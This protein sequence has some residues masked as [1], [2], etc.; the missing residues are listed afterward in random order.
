MPKQ[1]SAILLNRYIW[2]IDTIYSAGS[3]SREEIDRRW[4]RSLLSEGEMSIPPRT[5]HR[6]RIAIEE[7]FQI[8]IGF[9]KTRGYFIENTTDYQRQEMRKWLVN[10]FSV[11]N[12]INEGPHLRQHISF[13]D[14]PSS[15]RFLTTILEAIRDR[16]VLQVTHRGFTKPEPSTFR[17]KPYGL[18]VFKQRW[19]VL[20]ESEYADHQLRTYG[21]D[22]FESV[23]RLEEH[24]D[25]PEDFDIQEYFSGSYGITGLGQK[26]ELIKLEVNA[27]QR[28]YLRTLPLHASQKEI[29]TADDYSVFQFHLVPTF[30]LR[31]EILSFGPSAEVLSPQHFRDE[32]R[33]EVE[34]M[35]KLYNL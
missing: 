8:N 7:L 13:E 21:L 26:P 29:E 34:K 22:R 10:T 6:W 18:K 2:L 23:E 30:E 20:A 15:Q 32:L 24:Y 16:V 31:Q 27:Q 9:N 17:L 1:N 11:N 14:I 4:C 5:F 25:I 33:E 35:N 28:N 12:L 3:I 19:Y